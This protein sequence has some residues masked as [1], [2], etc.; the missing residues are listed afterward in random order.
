MD[1]QISLKFKML[2]FH[3]DHV[4]LL[5]QKGHSPYYWMDNDETIQFKGLPELNKIYSGLRKSRISEAYHTHALNVY[6]QLKRNPL[7]HDHEN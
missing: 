6:D 2:K 3:S 7:Q 5:C 4:D 1:H